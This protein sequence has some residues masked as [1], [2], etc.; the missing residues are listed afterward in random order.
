MIMSDIKV[1]SCDLE[2]YSSTELAQCGVYKYVEADDFEIL[3]FGYS[4]NGGSVHVIDLASGECI[5]NEIVEAMTDINVVKWAFNAQF[6]RICLS[7]WLGLPTGRYLDPQSWRC[8]M[9][10]SAYMGLPLSLEGAGA[11][12]GLEKKKLAEGKDLIRYFCKP[13]NPTNTNEN[14]KRN[15]PNHAP[16]KWT[17]FKIYN[18]RDVEAELAIQDKFVKFTVPDSLW[19]EYHL[20]Q[21]INDRGVALEKEL[22]THA[23]EADRRSSSELIRL[24]QELTELDNPNSVAQMKQWLLENGLETETLGKK[25]V[26]DLLKTAP[27]SL[28]QVLSLRLQL[29]KSSVKKYQAMENVVCLDDRVRGLFQFY[30]ANRTG[31]W[32]L[33]GDHEVL[34]KGGWQ[35]LD[36]WIGG[37]IACWNQNEIVSFQTADK[38]QF[39][40]DGDLY[41]Y[42][43][44]RISQISTPDHKMYVKRRYG[45]PWQI[46]TVENM[47]L[48]R[49]SIPFTGFRI[50]NA[51]LEN[52]QLRV[53]I[54]IQAD[55]HYLSDGGIKLKFTKLRKIE[56]CRT[57]L[58]QAEIMYTE[59]K[60][61]AAGKPAALFTIYAR[62]VPLWLR[63]F[64][65]KT[66]GSWLFDESPDIFFDELVHWDGYPSAKN[67][68]QYTTCNKQ[69]ADMVQAFAHLSGRSAI[70][71]TKERSSEHQN[72][73]TAY[74]VDIWLSPKNC[75]EI[76]P[77]PLK[78][79]YSGKVYCAVTSTGYF[80]VRR[81]GR[82]WVTG[83]SGRLLQPQ[84]LPQNHMPD[85]AQARE[86][87]RSGNYIALELLYDSVPEVLS[88]LIRTAFV[89]KPG[90][91]FIVADFAAIEA[92]VIAWLAGETWRVEVFA[93]GSDIYC[94]SASQMFRVPV[95]KHGING[96][97][98]QKGKIAELALGYGGSVGALKAMGALDMGLTEAELQPLVSAWRTSNPKIVRLWW[99]VDR[100]AMTA[101]RNKTSEHT[102]GILFEYRSGFLFITL[103]SG[104]RL[105][106]VKPRIEINRFGSDSVTYEGVGATKKWERIESYGPKFVEN[107]VQAT[108]RDILC[109]AMQSLRGIPIVMH[110]HDE[111]VIEA[112]KQ[113]TIE[114][115]CQQMGHTPPWAEGLLLRAD[116]YETEFYKKD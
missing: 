60:Q 101:V 83:N 6:E 105:S 9:V 80:L 76:R 94:A 107:I 54:M 103:P 53:L 14:R 78:F 45:A 69:N 50:V 77:K 21:E 15:L 7:R 66:F 10:W 23:I 85:L 1:I 111:I 115:I 109:Y 35:R 33:T 19:A 93:A 40:Y 96:H 12:L 13:C 99:D 92:R 8:S 38:V 34:T 74:V 84:N 59:T 95:E 17:L 3:L 112:D 106:Y 61:N 65:E 56:R 116:G 28:G 104:R 55:G 82:V 41:H 68:I 48:Y 63:L 97:L 52:R 11:V 113:L 58:R 72:W 49:P 71:R 64:R 16:D 29:A 87:L 67:S 62:H 20:D 30:G 73:N 4:V 44:K 89:P 18:Q 70:V 43:D 22:V 46:D 100:A 88:E 47:Q 114:S 42:N 39:D 110:V 25:A 2:T 79:H 102:H 26:S 37:E 108:S 27:D 24:M 75:H 98:R 32:C 81:E 36:G 86:L 5:P 91:R 57:L 90:C 51:N 31:R